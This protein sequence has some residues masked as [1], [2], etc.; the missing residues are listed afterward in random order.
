MGVSREEVQKGDGVYLL[1]EG[2][3]AINMLVNETYPYGLMPGEVGKDRRPEW[4]AVHG[5][6][7]KL[8][9]LC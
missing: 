5:G 9:G 2:K 6:K 3:G 8:K 1:E 7:L 4:E